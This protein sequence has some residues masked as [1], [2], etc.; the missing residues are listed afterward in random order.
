[1][2][3][4]RYYRAAARAAG[5]GKVLDPTLKCHGFDVVFADELHKTHIRTLGKGRGEA[6]LFAETKK[7]VVRDLVPIVHDDNGVRYP[8]V[9]KLNVRASVS[10]DRA[11]K[12]NY[13]RVVEAYAVERVCYP[14]TGDQA[15]GR[16]DALRLTCEAVL[17]A[18]ASDAACTVAAHFAKRAVRVIKKQ[19]KVTAVLRSRREHQAVGTDAG[20]PC[21]KLL[22]KLGSARRVK[23]FLDKIYDNEVVSGSVHFRKLH[24][25]LQRVSLQN[26]LYQYR[27][28]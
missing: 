19:L 22:R 1:M 15:C 4:R 27:P 28:F 25:V 6:E 18:V 20:A 12:V 24:I 7:L 23:L 17:K 14:L 10:L 11:L 21:A 9:A 26:R 8:G 13:A 16:L 3:E 5:E 2:R